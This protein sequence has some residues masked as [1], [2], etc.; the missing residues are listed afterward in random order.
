VLL[1][2][3]A[4]QLAVGALDDALAWCAAAEA[5]QAIGPAN[6]GGF[7]LYGGNRA[8]PYALWEAVAYSRSDTAERF[9]VAF[10]AHG[11]CLVVPPL[12]DVDHGGDL[13]ALARELA[14]LAA[15]LPAQRRL[16]A[17]LAATLGIADAAVRGSR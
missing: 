4:P 16:A 10:A 15:P 9:R 5:R 14:V 13:P 17:W 6:D 1:G 12:T 7:W 2:A 3:D 8:A 11:A